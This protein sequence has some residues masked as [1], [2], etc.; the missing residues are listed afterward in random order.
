[1]QTLA[2]YIAE[3]R[4]YLHDAQG[5]YYSDSDLTTAI[6]K[7]VQQR[8]RDSGMNRTIFSFSFSQGTQD[9]DIN[10]VATSST[11]LS[12]GSSRNAIGIWG[13]TL[14]WSNT[15][16]QMGRRAYTEITSFYQPYTGYQDVP[17]AYA[18]TGAT[19]IRIGPIP[20][21]TYASEWDLA[22]VSSPLVNSTDQDVL[23]YPW[24]DPVP[25][26]AASFA[27]LSLQQYDEAQQYEQKYQA[28]LASVVA[29]ADGAFMSDPYFQQRVRWP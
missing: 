8:D 17:V 10:S 16:Y 6:N 15:R 21:A 12:G 2:G 28:R 24:T 11:I 18:R 4:F 7:A 26:M 13:I 29:G 14:I 25:F 27:K 19:G 3:T 22:C 23:A 5:V 1:M 20:N 9:Y